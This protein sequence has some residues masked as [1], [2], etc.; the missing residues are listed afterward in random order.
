[1]DILEA[2]QLAVHNLVWIGEGPLEAYLF[3]RIAK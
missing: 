2:H 3:C 1:M